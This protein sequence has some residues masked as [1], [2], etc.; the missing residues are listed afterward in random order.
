MDMSSPVLVSSRMWLYVWGRRRCPSI[1]NYFSQVKPDLEIFVPSKAKN[2]QFKTAKLKTS[3][4]GWN[5]GHENGGPNRRAR[6]CQCIVECYEL[7]SICL[8]VCYRYWRG[9]V[10]WEPCADKSTHWS[11]VQLQPGSRRLPCFKLLPW[12]RQCGTVLPARSVL[13]TLDDLRPVSHT[14][15]ATNAETA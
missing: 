7:M 1:S 13:M 14:R 5:A 9:V 6:S 2:V 3:E 8:S 4:V 10:W 12:T 11:R 15:A